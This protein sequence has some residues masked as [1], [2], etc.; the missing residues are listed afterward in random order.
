[1]NNTEIE[2]STNDIYHFKDIIANNILPFYNL[3]NASIEEIKFKNTEKQRAVYKVTNGN[4]IFCLK[5]VYYNEADLLFVYSAM[6]WLYRNGIFVPRLLPT[7]DNNRFVLYDGMIFIL[8]HWINGEKC[9]FDN[10]SNVIDSSYNLGLMHKVSKNFK[11]IFGSNIKSGYDNIYMSHSK[12][13]QRLLDSANSAYF[14]KDK[15]SK[16]FLSDFDKNLKLAKFSTELAS[17]INFDK[18][19]K[20]L[21]HGDYVNKNILF[22]DEKVW[23][24]DFDKCSYNY[25]AYDIS[26]FLR[27][28]LKRNNTKWDVT[29]AL[30]VLESY[31]KEN[32]LNQDDIKYVLVYLSFPQKFW[33]LSKDYYNNI[34]KC[35]KFSFY[36]MLKNTTLKTDSQIEF[37]NTLTDSLKIIPSLKI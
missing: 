26:Y 8:S 7:I 9:D 5:K 34:S 25:S 28:L 29:L 15:F 2:K 31:S 22:E 13:M 12:H 23:V 14:N 17:S 19:S 33:R 24:I 18:L 4:N 1:M 6:E 21:C 10:I 36:T 3:Q 32:K 37:I 30:N 16:L 27:R 35:N 11:P 20:S